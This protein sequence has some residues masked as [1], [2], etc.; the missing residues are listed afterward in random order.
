MWGRNGVGGDVK[1]DFNSRV[2]VAVVADGV[3]VFH[4]K[5]P[6]FVS[7][8][9]L[10]LGWRRKTR[11][12]GRGGHVSNISKTSCLKGGHRDGS[13]GKG[14]DGDNRKEEKGGAGEEDER[15]NSRG[16]VFEG[17]SDDKM[18]EREGWTE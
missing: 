9:S 2:D 5:Q 11:K 6:H 17:P 4:I 3:S 12:R 10:A 16:E 1:R 7:N 18:M 13:K 15:S 8:D 14:G